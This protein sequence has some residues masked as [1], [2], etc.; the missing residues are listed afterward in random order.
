M[1]YDGNIYVGSPIRKTL[2][3][4]D[5]QTGEQLGKFENH[6]RKAPQEA[7]DDIVY[8]TNTKGY[9]YALDAD[10]GNVLGKK[11]LNKRDASAT[12]FNQE[13]ANSSAPLSPAGPVIINNTMFVGSQDSYVYSF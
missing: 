13:N 11:E 2:Y 5:Q 1:T 8:F 6:V 10:D 7:Q 12:P 4:Y 9:V 3:P